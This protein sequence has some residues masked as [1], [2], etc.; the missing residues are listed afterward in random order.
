MPQTRIRFKQTCTIA[1]P[2]VG[3][4]GRLTLGSA[5]SVTCALWRTRKRSY[6][7]QVGEAATVDAIAFVPSGTTVALRDRLVEGGLGYEVVGL[8]TAHDDYNRVDHIG[9]ELQL[10]SGAA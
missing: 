7:Q 9:L 1:R 2:T 10:V 6:V 3:A 8:T 5:T 4:D